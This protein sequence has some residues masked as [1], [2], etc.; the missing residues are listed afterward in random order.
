MGG[1]DAGSRFNLG[2][3]R[4]LDE[5]QGAVVQRNL[6]S[7]ESQPGGIFFRSLGF[8]G[9]CPSVALSF[10]LCSEALRCLVQGGPLL[11]SIAADLVDC[12]TDCAQTIRRTNL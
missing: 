12:N 4:E 1:D 8:D 11:Q 10:V 7:V 9:G 3:G 2:C 6:E 5:K